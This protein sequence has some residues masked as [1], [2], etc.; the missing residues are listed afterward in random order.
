MLDRFLVALR[1]R[2]VGDDGL[3]DRERRKLA[4]HWL[5]T[6]GPGARG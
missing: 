1:L 3:T 5:R 6:Y 4:D 2:R